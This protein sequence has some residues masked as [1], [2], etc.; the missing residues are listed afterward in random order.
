[1]SRLDAVREHLVQLDIRDKNWSTALADAQR[2][3]PEVDLGLTELSTPLFTLD[4][5]GLEH[6]ITTMRD[7]VAGHDA[8][9]A[10]HGKTTMCPALWKWQ[11]D[12]GSWAITVANEAQLRVARDA[13]LPRVVVANEFLSPQGLAWLA[14]E[15]DAD[16]GF[17]V[18]TWVDST[19]GVRLMTNALSAAGA[20]RQLSV[21]VEIGHPKARAGVRDHD[22]AL[23][24]A[25]AVIESPRLQLCGIA[26]YEGSVPGDPEARIAGVRAFLTAMGDLVTEISPLV[27][28][29]EMLITA[30]GSALFDLV[31]EVLGPIAAGTPN[32]RLLLRSGAY[33][34][35]DDGLYRQATPAAT[36]SGP[37]FTAAAHVWARVISNPEPDLV[38]LDV[39]K[40]D[41]PYDAG[42]P[43]V[44]KVIRDGVLVD[45]PITE[46]FNTN[47]QHAYV[48]VAEPGSLAVGEIVRLGLSHP[49][50]MFDKW[51]S[52]LLI[53][54]Q[55][56]R[57][58]GAI[59]TF[60]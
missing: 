33:V 1:M 29:E 46:V 51:R 19:D 49:C 54:G 28:A 4:L 21:C 45:A 22:D 5:E 47:D 2:Q 43:T 25:R 52:A 9:L 48:R 6:N 7:W 50:T 39:G 17:E 13:G 27:E 58:R 57:V 31:V 37:E 42:L 44:Q 11:V 36:R 38:L 12:Q 34:V 15:L 23:G 14:G 60:F 32:C 16:P 41:I 20:R 35:H 55:P 56:P 26:G 3:G 30:G 18:I 8:A 10:P 59:P 53:E 24:I 40:R